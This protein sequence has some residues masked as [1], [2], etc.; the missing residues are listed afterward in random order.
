[1]DCY[2]ET[3]VTDSSLICVVNARYEV[4]LQDLDMTSLTPEIVEIWLSLSQIKHIFNDFVAV[5]ILSFD[6]L[7]RGFALRT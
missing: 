1:M 5:G 7:D 4:A 2:F 3:L 6:L